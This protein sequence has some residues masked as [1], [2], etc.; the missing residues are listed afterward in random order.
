MAETQRMTVAELV[1]AIEKG[2]N[3]FNNY[4]ATLTPTQLTVPKD[5]AGWSAQDHV[6]HVA[7]WER[8]LIP[9]LDKGNRLSVL[10]IDAATWAEGD[11]VKIN[12]IM[13]QRSKNKTVEEARKYADDAHQQLVDKIKTLSDE[14]LYRPYNYY[15]P[16]SQYDTPAIDL[17]QDDTYHH[18]EEHTPWIAAIVANE[19][20]MSKADLLAAIDKGWNDFN[21]YLISLTPTQVTV[22]MDAA[23]WRALDH[24]IHLADWENGVLAM[25]NK[26]DRAAGMGVDKATWATQDFDK[27]NDILQKKSKDKTLEQAREFVMGVHTRLVDKVQSMSDEDLQ[28]PYN[29]YQPESDREVPVI[30]WVQMNTYQH[31]AEHQPWIATI[32][33]D[34][35]P[36]S[37][38][39]LLD[40]L[41][42][43][44]ESVN[45]F[46]APLTDTQL[47]LLT[48]AGGWTVKDHVIHVAAWEDGLTALLDKQDRRTH[49]DIDEATWS[50][51]DD[52][53]NAVIQKRYKDLSWAGVQQKRQEIHHKLLKQIDAMND[54]TLQGAY[55]AYNTNSKSSRSITEYVSGQTF[56]HYAVHI[57]WMAAIAANKAQISKAALLKQVQAGWDTVNTFIT[58]LSDTQ[59]TQL[60]DTA[61]WTVK[62]HVIHLAAWEDGLTALLDKQDRRTHMDID[63]ATWDAGDDPINA[64]LQKRYKDLTWAEVLEKRQTI[65][66]KLLNQ[67]NAI[68][69]ETL[70]EPFSAFNPHTKMKHTIADYISGTT[71]DHYVEHIPWM[72]AIA[73]GQ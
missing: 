32:V 72:A 28:R 51:G 35:K 3:D 19:Q 54:E 14:D 4:L 11:Y 38:A 64:V 49:M 59:K 48:D 39:E 7:D 50:S 13:Q 37:K 69:E 2:W 46:L 73:K 63:E 6:I 29:Y 16:E 62:D 26:Q 31:Y 57:P 41:Q 42:T 53:I 68:S 44:W 33:A 27:I 71:P 8:S 24:V 30:K 43:G 17:L 40:K 21:A 23:G 12:G 34:Q 15:Q 61:G 36:L 66:D 9:F 25:L 60:T 18:Y 5:A 20:S 22:P 65:H 10:G 56:D 67:I 58:G 45:N 55:G 70:H 52:P 1:A 47:L